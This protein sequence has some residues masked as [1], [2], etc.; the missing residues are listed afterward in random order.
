MA[1][2]PAFQFIVQ[3]PGTPRL[4]DLDG[5][6]A[7]R[8]GGHGEGAEVFINTRAEAQAFIDIFTEA[9]A[10]LPEDDDGVQ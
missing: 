6:V 9:K 10:L 5:F 7:V 2:R 3:D 8:I 1:R 4:V